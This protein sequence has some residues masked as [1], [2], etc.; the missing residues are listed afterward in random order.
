[1]FP[2]TYLST[3][4]NTE[5]SLELMAREI[6]L[7]T[8]Y[9]VYVENVWNNA[10]VWR[11]ISMFA[12]LLLILYKKKIRLFTSKEEKLEHDK[13]IFINSDLIMTENFLKE[14]LI[15]LSINESYNKSKYQKI[16]DFCN[17]FEN[18]SYINS[19]L[20]ESIKSFCEMLRELQEFLIKHFS[21]INIPEVFRL[22]PDLKHDPTFNYLEFQE[23]LNKLCCRIEN[24]YI[25]YRLNIRTN[26]SI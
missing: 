26:L 4:F 19:S 14:F 16:S 1:M 17:F 9:V 25:K 15:E 5:T 6:W 7:R 11:T 13:N 23:E 10:D 12:I 22:Y 20:N 18:N 24:H 2:I 3:I 8:F 21:E